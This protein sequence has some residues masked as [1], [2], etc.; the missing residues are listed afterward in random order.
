GFDLMVDLLEHADEV[1]LSCF[2]L[3]ASEGVNE[4][5]VEYIKKTYQNIRIAGNHHGFFKEDDVSIAELV[6]ESNPDLIFVA[7]G[8]PKQ[9]YW[10]TNYISSFTKGTF[11]GVGGSFDVLAGEVK[12]AP[13]IWIKLNLEWLYRIV[14]QP[15][16][17]FRIMNVFKFIGLSLLKRT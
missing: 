2:L 8:F 10:I 11:I 4:K 16:R 1:G 9:E 5:T 15:A 14:K 3:G 6:R 13:S 7:L 12:R 17:I